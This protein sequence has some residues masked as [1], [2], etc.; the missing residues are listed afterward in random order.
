MTD[1][2]IAIAINHEKDCYCNLCQR[3]FKFIGLAPHGDVFSDED[4][5]HKFLNIRE[6]FIDEWRDAK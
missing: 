4:F 6:G 3:L 2:E 1:A 5:N